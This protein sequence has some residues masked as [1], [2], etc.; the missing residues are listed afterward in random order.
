MTIFLAK[1]DTRDVV[2]QEEE[3]ENSV[4]L[5]YPEAMKTLK[6]ENDKSIL[7]KAY[8]FMQKKRI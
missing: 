8:A 4:W 7:K 1:S 6:F 5:S 2:L 3:I